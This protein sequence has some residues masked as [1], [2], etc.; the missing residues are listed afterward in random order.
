M[1]RVQRG[2]WMLTLAVWPSVGSG[3]GLARKPWLFRLADPWVVRPGLVICRVQRLKY[4]KETFDISVG[5]ATR[6]PSSCSQLW[7]LHSPMMHPEHR[8]KRRHL[9]FAHVPI[10][11][12]ADKDVYV[13]VYAF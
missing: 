7:V 3:A 11:E 1:E 4:G 12:P 9:I 10:C 5:E 6:R 8:I 13:V 2:R